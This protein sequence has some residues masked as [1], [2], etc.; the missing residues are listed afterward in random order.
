MRVYKVFMLKLL[1]MNPNV[2]QVQIDRK[3]SICT[4]YLK[5]IYW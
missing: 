3:T 5:Y 4:K 1:R 2:T